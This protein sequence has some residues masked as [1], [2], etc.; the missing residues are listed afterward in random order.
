MSIKKK[1]PSKRI[2]RVLHDKHH[3]Y[4]SI[5]NQP[6]EDATLSWAA[7][8]LLCYLLSKSDNWAA[9]GKE[10]C[11]HATNGQNSTYHTLKEFGR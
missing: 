3:P 6:L 5:S 1:T 9:C 2:H 11:Q 10:L 8:G 4:T 7:K